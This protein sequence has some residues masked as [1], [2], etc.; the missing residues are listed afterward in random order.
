MLRK[1]VQ[2]VSLLGSNAY[3]PGFWRGSIYKGN[4]KSVCIPGLNCYSCPG[5]LA[6]CPLGSLQAMLSSARFGFG[7]YVIGL[8][9][10]FGALFGRFVCGFLC[11]FGLMQELLYKI[12]F[13]RP[14]KRT[15]C[16]VLG[17]PRYIKYVVLAVFVIGMPLFAG[18][19]AGVSDPAFCKYICPAGTLTAGLPLLSVNHSLRG[20]IGGLFFWKLAVALVVVMGSLLILRF[21]CKYL[22]PL[23]AIYALF[24]R[25]ALYRLR[26]TPEN[27]VKCGACV[28]ICP[29]EVDPSRN[30]DSAE[31]IRCG[32][33]AKACRFSALHAGF[34]KGER[35][36]GDVP[37]SSGAKNS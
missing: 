3:L 8:L 37:C 32:D 30:P 33:C 1:I 35:S 14:L 10:A 25:V 5:A 23:G 9:L 2:W 13:P 24:N 22:C 19:E 15:A 12:P 18:G 26:L 17:W 31:C 6:S 28:R 4:L 36:A 7:Y 27:C 34:A 16:N 29:M 11:P 21:F 20:A